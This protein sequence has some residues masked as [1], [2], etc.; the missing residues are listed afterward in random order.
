[1]E[2]PR[3]TSS[4]QKQSIDTYK[5]E[6]NELSTIVKSL[7]MKSQQISVPSSDK[8]KEK[9]GVNGSAAKEKKHKLPSSDR[10]KKKKIK[11]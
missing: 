8:P 4:E 6:K 10:P 1:M 11:V 7:K 9:T 2:L 3:E 5:K